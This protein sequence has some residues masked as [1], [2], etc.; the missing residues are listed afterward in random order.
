M[1]TAGS[2]KIIFRINYVTKVLFEMNGRLMFSDAMKSFF[3]Y[4]TDELSQIY[5]TGKREDIKNR[6]N[7]RNYIER[8]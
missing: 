4:R 6:S 1:V 5:P 8:F 7:K 3:K 2:D